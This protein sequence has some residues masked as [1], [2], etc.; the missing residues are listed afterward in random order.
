MDSGNPD[1]GGPRLRRVTAGNA[2][3][4]TGAGTNT[5]IVGTGAVVVIDPGPPDDPAH[6][7]ATCAALDPGEQVARVLVTHAHADHCGAAA[8]LARATGAPVLGHPG[9][10]AVPRGG[11][12]A[13]AGPAPV[14]GPEPDAVGFRPDIAIDEGDRIALDWGTIT[15]LHVPGHHPGHLAFAV[16]DLVFPGDTV[17]GWA[18]TLIAPPD[19]DLAA[20]RRSVARLRDLGARVFLPGHGDPVLDPAARCAALLRHRAAREAMVR[21]A[22][23]AGLTALPDLVRAVYA[24]TPPA[25]HPA[26][27]GNLLA[28]LLDLAARDQVQAP[29][30]AR[31]PASR[32]VLTPPH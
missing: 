17:M 7:A 19:G 5:W 6:V 11:P 9:T 25:L 1:P 28:H 30:D 20:Y 22:L 15:V 29:A 18:S 8:A 3:P 13:A 10:G 27:A 24:D 26:A 32:W 31:S 23:A 14:A 4:L 2:G 16:G 21:A 12:G